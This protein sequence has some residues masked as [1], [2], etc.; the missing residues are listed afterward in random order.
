M[1]KSMTVS[2]G[3]DITFFYHLS[4]I[5]T[6]H[7]LSEAQRRR[8]ARQKGIELRARE[9]AAAARASTARAS[10]PPPPHLTGP[11]DETHEGG[12]RC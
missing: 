7:T 9:A 4:W 6:E 10:T 12:R 5:S 1:M 2:V 8:K 3:V 11:N